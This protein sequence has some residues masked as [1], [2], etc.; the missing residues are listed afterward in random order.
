MTFDQHSTFAISKVV[1]VVSQAANVLVVDITP[2]DGSLF[3]V[4]QQL[5]I[6]TLSQN[7]PFSFMGNAMIARLTGIATDRLTI[8]YSG[9]NREG[10]NVHTVQVGDYISNS[11]TPKAL[12]DIETAVNGKENALGYT[13]E[14]VANKTTDGTLA[15]NSDML[16]PS[17]KAVKTYVDN[18]SGGGGG[19][20]TTGYVAKSGNNLKIAIT[21][22]GQ[23]TLDLANVLIPSVTWHDY[24]I[25]LMDDQSNGSTDGITHLLN[26]TGIFTFLNFFPIGSTPKQLKVQ[27]FLEDINDDNDCR[28]DVTSFFDIDTLNNGTKITGFSF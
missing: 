1:N 8:S 20:N 3:A 5:T 27:I 9:G 22:L 25:W 19:L 11:I 24:Q 23:D 15:S 13:P 17:E 18:H 2:G 4:N 16:Y 21:H 28:V 7:A 26:T 14:N 6:A 10:T 12:T